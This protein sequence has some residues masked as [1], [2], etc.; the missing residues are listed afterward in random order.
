MAQ[1]IIPPAPS[2]GGTPSGSDTQVQFNDGGAFG[3]DSGLVYAKATDTLTTGTLIASSTIRNGWV[4]QIV[5]ATKPT[6]R[7]SGSALVVD[8]LWYNTTTN[9]NWFWNGTYW[10]SQYQYF[11]STFTGFLGAT[12]TILCPERIPLIPSTFGN[13]FFVEN[14][15]RN[16]LLA[17]SDATNYWQL[18]AQILRSNNVAAN[19]TGASA[20]NLQHP[21]NNS[22]TQVI[23]S[24]VASD[25]VG[26][27]VLL[28][29]FG[30]APN[31]I[32]A[33][34]SFNGRLIAP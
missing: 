11:F 23:N 12:N 18:Q 29:K 28:T 4:E 1:I 8:D 16:V 9:T 21:T 15:T 34:F 22:G 20:V 27:Q 6:T 5:S 10:L 24:V 25:A 17:G 30:S 33:V 7:V 3:G 26:L 14:C 13:S 32:N 31:I 2:G 19:L